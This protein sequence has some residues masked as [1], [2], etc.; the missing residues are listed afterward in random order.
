MAD[1]VIRDMG[2]DDMVGKAY[3]HWRRWQEAYTGLLDADYLNSRPLKQC[4][5]MAFRW[6]DRTLVAVLNG[7]IVAFANYGTPAEEDPSTG[8]I[9]AIYVLQAFYGLGIGRALMDV[10]MQRLD[11]CHSV[12]LWVLEGNERAIRFY[13]R[14]GFLPDGGRQEV[15]LGSPRTEIRMRYN[16]TTA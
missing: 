15:V 1:F 9:H 6:P 5:Q 16:R 11:S 2:P 4:E 7:Q 3:V 14:Y 12:V 13:Q 10:C 8:E